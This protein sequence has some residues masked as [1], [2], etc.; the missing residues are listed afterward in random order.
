[1][2][3]VLSRMYLY[4]TEVKV[5]EGQ[6]ISP[7]ISDVI[8]RHNHDNDVMYAANTRPTTGVTD[9]GKKY[10]LYMGYRAAILALRLDKN[11]VK[12][13]VLRGNPQDILSELNVRYRV[14][15][16]YGRT[17]PIEREL[18]VCLSYAL[19]LDEPEAPEERDEPDE[20]DESDG[21][22]SSDR[23]EK[24]DEEDEEPDIPLSPELEKFVKNGGSK[25]A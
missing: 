9:D 7:H 2:L 16:P 1:M 10:V 24:E 19:S 8:K 4:E 12:I 21:K 5:K 22:E 6:D 17:D 20:P 18:K 23:A 3:E 15:A 13:I 11:K 25:G 14:F